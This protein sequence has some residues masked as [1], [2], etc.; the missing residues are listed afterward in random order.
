MDEARG[1][2]S[3]SLQIGW[4]VDTVLDL[5]RDGRPKGPSPEQHRRE[6]FDPNAAGRRPGRPAPI[7]GSGW[8]LT[9]IWIVGRDES[10]HGWAP[11]SASHESRRTGSWGRSVA[12][13]REG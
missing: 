4:R 9:A 5:R 3:L 6:P 8:D 7:P 12:K 10:R 13:R 1:R 2:V 11:A